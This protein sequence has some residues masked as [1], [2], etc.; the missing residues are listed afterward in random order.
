[1]IGL[2]KWECVVQHTL[3]D[4]IAYLTISDNNGE[5][6]FKLEIINS[7]K[8]IPEFVITDIKENGSTLECMLKVKLVPMK[9]PLIASFEGDTMNAKAKIPY[10]GDL[11]LENAKKIG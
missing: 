2:G 6:D 4:G 1:M 8:K 3:F 10:V 5:Y 7:T 11:V 9:I